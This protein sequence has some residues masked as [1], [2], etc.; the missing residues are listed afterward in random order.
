MKSCIGDRFGS[1]RGDSISSHDNTKTYGF[2]NPNPNPN[3]KTE[4]LQRTS[5]NGDRYEKVYS[6]TITTTKGTMKL[7][8]FA[9]DTPMTVNNFVSSPAMDFTTTRYF[10]ELSKVL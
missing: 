5:G 3:P 8:L 9:Q 4:N 1:D 2:S 6:V 7:T 10:T